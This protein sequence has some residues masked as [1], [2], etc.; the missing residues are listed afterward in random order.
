ML[1]FFLHFLQ[2]T[3]YVRHSNIFQIFFRII[4]HDFQPR[5][6]LG[7]F[8][9]GLIDDLGEPALQLAY[10][11]GETGPAFSLN[12]IH[13]G[14]SLGQVDT[15]IDKGPFRKF[16]GIGHAGTTAQY[17]LQDRFQCFPAAMALDFQY[18]FCRIGVRAFH[19]K[20]QD[21][22]DTA[23]IFID[24][25]PVLN[26]TITAF[27]QGNCRFTFKYFISYSIGIGSADTDCTDTAFSQRCRNRR[28][29]ICRIVHT[30]TPF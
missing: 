18:V 19:D 9:A 25:S 17:E 3:G 29:G 23:P 26:R 4:N 8:F 5:H 12:H 7:Q 28:N 21:F 24:N 15:A 14:L 2:S 27:L 30:N 11:T 20:G 13:D 16:T 22:I 1:Q 6:Q 10:S